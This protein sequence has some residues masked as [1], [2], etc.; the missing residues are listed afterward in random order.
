MPR[1]W[2][3]TQRR[4]TL[5]LVAI[6]RQRRRIAFLVGLTLLLVLIV[7]LSLSAKGN[8][9]LVKVVSARSWILTQPL[10]EVLVVVGLLV[11]LA[12]WLLP[13][14]QTARSQGLTTGNRFDRENSD[15]KEALKVA[16]TMGFRWS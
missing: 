4:K 12:L 6:S 14:W 8:L 16:G 1:T 3:F 5:R 2:A 15:L 10:P 11:V 13:R 9:W 7:W